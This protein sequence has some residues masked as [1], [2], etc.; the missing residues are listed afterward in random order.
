M[1][2]NQALWLL[3]QTMSPFP[4]WQLLSKGSPIH[5]IPSV[6]PTLI[7]SA[8]AAGTPPVLNWSPEEAA[9]CLG[10]DLSAEWEASEVPESVEVVS[11]A[12]YDRIL[13]PFVL[14]GPEIKGWVLFDCQ[15]THKVLISHYQ[16]R[17]YILESGSV[18][19][20]SVD[21][22]S[23][24]SLNSLLGTIYQRYPRFLD[25]SSRIV[26]Y[27]FKNYWSADRILYH[28]SSHSK[29]KPFVE[30]IPPDSCASPLLSVLNSLS[31]LIKVRGKVKSAL[32]H[33]LPH[34]ESTAGL[35]NL[36]NT[37][38]M[39]SVLQCLIHIP[40]VAI[41]YR[42]WVKDW[43]QPLNCA[44][45]ELI[46]DAY[47]QEKGSLNADLVRKVLGKC[48]QDGTQQD[49]EEFL[50]TL[51]GTL[52]NEQQIAAPSLPPPY[53]PPQSPLL[54]LQNDLKGSFLAQLFSGFIE[55]TRKCENCGYETVGEPLSPFLLLRLG[56]IPSREYTIRLIHWPPT[57]LDREIRL[58]V[59]GE[60]G[61]NVYYKDLERE[62]ML[63]IGENRVF[64]GTSS[65]GLFEG[66]KE[67]S[68]QPQEHLLMAYSLP[69]PLPPGQIPLFLDIS[70]EI[71]P[72]KT[73][74]CL[75]SESAAP[76]SVPLFISRYLLT[77]SNAYFQA[78]SYFRRGKS[79]LDETKVGDL[80]QSMSISV[81]IWRENQ[82]FRVNL[83]DCERDWQ[84]HTVVELKAVCIGEIR[85]ICV[86]LGLPAAIQRALDYFK[87]AKTA[88]KADFGAT[89]L[90]LLEYSLRSKL[91]I[92]TCPNCPQFPLFSHRQ[93]R[94]F[95]P[96][97]IIHIARGESA[98][99][100][101]SKSCFQVHFPCSDLD[102]TS[103][104][105]STAVSA[106]KYDLAG[107]VLH[108]G[109][110]LTNGHYVAFAKNP[111][112]GK[113]YYCSDEKTQLVP[114]TDVMAAEAA[115]MLVYIHK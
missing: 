58:K 23:N 47:E 67:L 85:L 32:F 80:A 114:E 105:A 45:A 25:Y 9:S 62:I 83:Y 61:S 59:P 41:F 87:P 111:V 24:E 92:D 22:A 63:K 21:F 115:S 16:I 11:S 2:E 4:S 98:Q 50:L 96:V 44:L 57:V 19:T 73:G 112:S 113:W 33:W 76:S 18:R 37:C 90:Q 93:I 108:K 48:W 43:D 15:F 14:S 46:R 70:S 40:A 49:A 56:L 91:C 27:N 1:E 88:I 60:L 109:A 3:E 31:I 13:R 94:K 97:L 54:R 34:C 101:L 20:D 106:A 55:T 102:L 8:L 17:L 82:L 103:F 42:K 30:A 99:G 10:P 77:L 53:F 72:V 104:E 26:F 86:V 81:E 38:Y 79:D 52:I 36:G 7:S 12:V 6:W 65:R 69:D 28:L 110:G 5:L 71:S 66:P 84:I 35:R 74:L 95:P 64:L 89:L 68:Q 39:N 29:L 75:C 51:L 107:V 78:E 100:H